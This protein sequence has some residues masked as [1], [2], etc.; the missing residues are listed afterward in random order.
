[1]ILKIWVE[2]FHPIDLHQKEK[3]SL[4]YLRN[5]GFKISAATFYRLKKEIQESTRERLNLIANTEYLQQ[6]IDRL[7][8]LNTIH[9]EL[10][11]QY[12]RETNPTKKAN[13][14]MQ[15]AEMQIYLSSYYDSTRYVMEQ[16][17]KI[18]QQ[19]PLDKKKKRKLENEYQ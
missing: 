18:K 5:K 6:H 10:W 13:I 9:N 7:N 19:E 3:E 2:Q 1:M 15:I 17:A 14:L 16:G 8:N 11:E 4:N 12:K